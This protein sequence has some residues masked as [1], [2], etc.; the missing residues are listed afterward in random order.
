MAGETGLR[1]RFFP[2]QEPQYRDD[3]RNLEKS[4]LDQLADVADDRMKTLLL[5]FLGTGI[6]VSELRFFTVESVR[7][8]RVIVDNKGKTRKSIYSAFP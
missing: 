2:F 5:T 4:D 6:R 3:N 7:D 1:C 8:G